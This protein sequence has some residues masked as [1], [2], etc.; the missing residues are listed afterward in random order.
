MSYVTEKNTAN[1]ENCSYCE[2][3]VSNSAKV[4]DF[5]AIRFGLRAIR[6]GFD[7]ISCRFAIRRFTRMKQISQVLEHESHE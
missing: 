4:S 3:V 6:F 2:R 7:A 5:G 1:V